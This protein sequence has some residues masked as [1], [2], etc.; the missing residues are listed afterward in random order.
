ME[1]HAD[2][3]FLEGWYMSIIIISQNLDLLVMATYLFHFDD[4]TMQTSKQTYM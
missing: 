2:L 1:N 3:N 4:V